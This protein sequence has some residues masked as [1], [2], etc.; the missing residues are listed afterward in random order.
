MWLTE[1]YVKRLDLIIADSFTT[2]SLRQKALRPTKAKFALQWDMCEFFAHLGEVGRVVAWC[3]GVR[4][5][6]TW[7]MMVNSALKYK[8]V[9]DQTSKVWL[10]PAFWGVEDSGAVILGRMLRE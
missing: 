2:Y 6:D 1:R 5:Y 3:N 8:P 7:E 9:Y 10:E 4:L